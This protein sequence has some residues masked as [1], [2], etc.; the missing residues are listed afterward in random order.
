MTAETIWKYPLPSPVTEIELP[1]NAAVRH[2]AID[3]ASGNPA[4]WV[5]LNPIAGRVKR[6]FRVHGT[7]H[8][9]DSNC[10]FLGTVIMAGSLVW[11]V[12]E[13]TTDHAR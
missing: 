12:F 9:I 2:V 1:W 13:R 10:E 8:P 7:G 4:I 11:H 3:P 6:T 5:Q